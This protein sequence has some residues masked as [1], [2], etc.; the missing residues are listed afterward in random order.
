MAWHP[1]DVLRL[2]FAVLVAVMVIAGLTTRARPHTARQWTLVWA[3]VVFLAWV[4][5][6]YAWLRA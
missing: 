5:L 2:T 6:G 3:V 1:L 4:L